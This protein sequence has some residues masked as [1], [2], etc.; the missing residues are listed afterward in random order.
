MVI[1]VPFLV[2][3][4]RQYPTH[5]FAGQTL[6]GLFGFLIVTWLATNFLGLC[7]GWGLKEKLGRL[8][9]LERPFDKTEKHFVG[10]ARPSYSGL[11]DPHEDVGYLLVHDDNLEFFGGTQR[12][13]LEK[14][15]VKKIGFRANPHSVLGLGRWVS[16][17]AVVKEKPVRFLVEPREKST[18]IG[19]VFYGTRLRKRL[20]AWF[21]FKI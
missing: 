16:V 15:S 5:G 7:G 9:H 11:L 8:L 3:G 21:D 18:L 14:A 19:N 20:E 10:F 17:E 6:V 2:Y 13:S 1:G 4:V 12:I